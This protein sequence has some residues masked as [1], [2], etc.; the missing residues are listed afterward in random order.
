MKSVAKRAIP[1][2]LAGLLGVALSAVSFWR[3]PQ[4][5]TELVCRF[6]EPA[7]LIPAEI[8]FKPEPMFYT[9]WARAHNY[10]SIARVQVTLGAN[11]LVSDVTL[12][13]PLPEEVAGEVLNVA[14]SIEFIPALRNGTPE[15][16]T[17]I[18]EYKLDG[19]PKGSG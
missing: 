10:S 16:S 8:V 13:T 3:T 17:V 1:F 12:L 2:A 11:Y 5:A 9:N 4:P 6:T 19:R 18:V 7:P 15:E 14:R